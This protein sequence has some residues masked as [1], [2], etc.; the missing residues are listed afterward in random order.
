M[1]LSDFTEI[2]FIDLGLAKVNFA[3]VE[4]LRCRGK[5]RSSRILTNLQVPLHGHTYAGSGSG[6]QTSPPDEEREI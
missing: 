2:E 6:T 4:Q 5:G 3:T 1:S